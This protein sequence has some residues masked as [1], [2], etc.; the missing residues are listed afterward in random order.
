M[1]EIKPVKIDKVS[2]SL[3]IFNLHSNQKIILNDSFDIFNN[4]YFLD[5]QRLEKKY[6]FYQKDKIKKWNFSNL[7]LANLEIRN[8]RKNICAIL[9]VGSKINTII[10]PKKSKI[11]I[12]S[13]KILEII[14]LSKNKN[15]FIFN[16]NNFYSR[17]NIFNNYKLENIV[18]LDQYAHHI[19]VITNRV[20]FYN[21]EF[22][23]GLNNYSFCALVKKAKQKE[24]EHYIRKVSF[25]RK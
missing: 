13:D 23:N 21:F 8:L 4:G 17:Y 3:S 20:G 18:E 25:T 12:S 14:L 22:N 16:N 1:K 7:Y 5:E 2:S 24:Y 9:D 10:N 11:K 15:K 6:L 19:W